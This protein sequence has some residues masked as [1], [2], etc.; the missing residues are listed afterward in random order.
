MIVKNEEQNL[1]DSLKSIYDKVD[2]III[3]DTGSTDKTKNI[4]AEFTDK[5]YDFEWCNDFSAAR[6]YSVQM[7][8]NDWV[9][10]LDADEIITH[11]NERSVEDFM[12]KEPRCAGR[13]KR[14]D[15][16][17]DLEGT[18]R[19]SNRISR[20]FNKNYYMYKGIFH[21]QVVSISQNDISTKSVDISADHIGYM[22]EVI[23][24]TDKLGRNLQML[25]NA[26]KIDKK[27][28]YLHYQLGKTFFMA[29]EF[30]KACDSFQRALS[31]GADF[32]Y[33]Y[34]GDLIGCLGYSL[35]NS[36]KYKE[37]LEILK[38]EKYYSGDKDFLFLS[39]LIYMNNA[40]FNEAVNSFK[41]CIGGKDGNMEGV[42]S[43]LPNYNIGVIYDCLGYKKEA[44]T[45]YGNCGGYIPAQKRLAEIW[46][47]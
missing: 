22:K 26:L 27:D 18:K 25:E 31:L 37:A 8:S 24:R 42:N 28:Q 6:N 20:L 19:Y 4:A 3:A 29:K 43:Y 47:T 7:A 39:G 17:E 32:K 33:E 41:Q 23:N 16:F 15:I 36:G 12:I 1:R 9:L 21:E 10:I 45:Y 40:M 38:Y 13:I 11:F 5:I 35:I 46:T 2:E 34:V 30:S 44:I 14:V